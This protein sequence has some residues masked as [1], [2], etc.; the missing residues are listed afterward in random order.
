MKTK[1]KT[2]QEFLGYFI[3]NS[4]NS[5]GFVP[6]LSN[7]NSHLYQTHLGNHS[8]IEKAQE[9][10]LFDYMLNRPEKFYGLLSAKFI[11]GTGLHNEGSILLKAIEADGLRLPRELKFDN[12]CNNSILINGKPFG[13]L[14]HNKNKNESSAEKKSFKTGQIVCIDIDLFLVVSAGTEQVIV[15]QLSNNLTP[16]NGNNFR[17]PLECVELSKRHVNYILKIDGITS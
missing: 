1:D 5:D 7:G 13:A 12:D 3:R 15:R 11:Y 4:G 10:V 2:D 16:T 14:S 8:T 17:L 6:F 9:A